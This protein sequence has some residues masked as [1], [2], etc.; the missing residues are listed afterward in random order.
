M[1]QVQARQLSCE[2]GVLPPVA[3]VSAAVEPHVRLRPPEH[4]SGVAQREQWAVPA[5]QRGAVPED[6]RNVVGA[7]ITRPALEDAELARVVDADVQRGVPALGESDQC[8][9]RA[10]RNGAVPRV[11]RSHDV[12]CDKRL[13]ALVAADPV[14]PLLVGE[15]ARRAERHD[16]DDR[17]HAVQGDELVLDDSHAYRRQE[18]TRPPWEAVQEI[19]DR[20]AAVRM[21]AIAGRQVDVD[22]LSAASDRGA[23]D[24]EAASRAVHLH[25]GG[26]MRRREAAIHPVVLDVSVRTEDTD[27]E[28]GGERGS[29]GPRPA[30][31]GEARCDHGLVVRQVA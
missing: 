12:P 22:G 15:R 13:P 19:C 24:V 5:E 9:S 8:A 11:D 1:S 31:G 7:L 6:R 10:A 29:R 18:S 4:R 21:R 28:E 20:V 3:I 25:E 17:A 26:V 14:C 30:G 23:H 2:R 16:E 27:S